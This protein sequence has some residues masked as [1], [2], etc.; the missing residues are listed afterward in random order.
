MR[1]GSVV[2]S[3]EGKQDRH[4]GGPSVGTQES[5]IIKGVP[6]KDNMKRKRGIVDSMKEGGGELVGYE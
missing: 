6:Q 5:K 3:K 2:K 4:K 1:C